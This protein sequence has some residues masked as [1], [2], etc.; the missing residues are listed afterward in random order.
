MHKT[1]AVHK[2]QPR[3]FEGTQKLQDSPNKTVKCLESLEMHQQPIP[4]LQKYY[5]PQRKQQH[6]QTD[7][8]TDLRC[9]MC[10]EL[11]YMNR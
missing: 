10:G 2:S 6:Y 11:D 5:G 1:A 3:S 4:R 9:W 8:G 7:D